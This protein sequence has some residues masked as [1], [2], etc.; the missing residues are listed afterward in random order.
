MGAFAAWLKISM[1]PYKSKADSTYI[2]IMYS[3]LLFHT[4]V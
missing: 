3:K 4:K 2:L 1:F